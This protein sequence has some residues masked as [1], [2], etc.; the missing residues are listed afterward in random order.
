M[1]SAMWSVARNEGK[2]TV[3]LTGEQAVAKMT[4][5]PTSR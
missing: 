3:F 5:A 2:K 1:D 4:T